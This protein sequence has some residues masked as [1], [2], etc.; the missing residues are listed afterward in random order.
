MRA[1]VDTNVLISFLFSGER[2]GG[3]V[4][5]LIQGAVLGEFELLLPEAL[6]DE[7]GRKR[8]TNAE[9]ARRISP[10]ESAEFVALLRSIAILP[11]AIREPIPAVVRNPKDDYLLAYALLYEADFLVTRDKDLLV[12]RQVEHLLL[13]GPIQFVR[14]HLDRGAPAEE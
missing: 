10:E 13:V 3:T 4:R 9:L 8:R 1:L 5:R 11:P 2:A 6:L 14:E 7:L 12:L